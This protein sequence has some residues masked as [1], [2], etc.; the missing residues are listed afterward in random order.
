VGEP[1]DIAAGACEAVHESRP[2]GIRGAEQ[3]DRD[4]PGGVLRGQGSRGALRHDQVG[5]QAEAFA[6]KDGKLVNLAIRGQ[7]VNDDAL[8]LDVAELVQAAQERV[9]AAQSCTDG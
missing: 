1:R 4:G 9:I 7:I 8:A 3:D 2:D 5:L 6:G